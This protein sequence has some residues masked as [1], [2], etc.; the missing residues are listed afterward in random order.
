MN[1]LFCRLELDINKVL[2]TDACYE[3]VYASVVGDGSNDIITVVSND[4]TSTTK[5]IR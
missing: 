4:E 3:V 1:M 5:I 2:R